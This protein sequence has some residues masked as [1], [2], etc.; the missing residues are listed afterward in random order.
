[1][2]HCKKHKTFERILCSSLITACCE[3]SLNSSVYLQEKDD[4]NGVTFWHNGE[5]A[6][7]QH[8]DAA[9]DV[10]DPADRW[11]ER[12]SKYHWLLSLISQAQR[13]LKFL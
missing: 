9:D 4:N 8:G 3:G 12:A 10:D 7:P 1:M 13:V 6:I 2:R 5:L 11:E